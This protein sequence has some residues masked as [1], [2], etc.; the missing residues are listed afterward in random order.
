MTNLEFLR[1]LEAAWK[2]SF[3][4]ETIEG[5]WCLEL[6]SSDSLFI[7][8]QEKCLIQFEIHSLSLDIVSKRVVSVYHCT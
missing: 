7:G 5:C 8:Q 4:K 6:P 1:D 3:S 2:G